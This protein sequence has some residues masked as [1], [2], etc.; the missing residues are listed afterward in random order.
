MPTWGSAQ[1]L[2]LLLCAMLLAHLLGYHLWR[3]KQAGLLRTN[4]NPNPNSNPNPNPSPDH[5]SNPNPSPDPNSNP[6]P[7]PDH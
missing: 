7:D 1:Y 4:P 5:N 3:A 6:D 2:A